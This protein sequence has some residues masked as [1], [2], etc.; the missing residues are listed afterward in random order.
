MNKISILTEFCIFDEEQLALKKLVDYENAK[1]SNI[2]NEVAY[3]IKLDRIAY[4]L[5]LKTKKLWELNHQQTY[6][7][8]FVLVT[9]FLL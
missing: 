2:S 6:L 4:K 9:K 7:L 8:C 3:I 5:I 1:K